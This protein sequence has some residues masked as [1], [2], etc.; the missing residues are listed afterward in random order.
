MNPHSHYMYMTP[1]LSFHSPPPPGPTVLIL[2]P[3][4]TAEWHSCYF[5]Q[6]R[7]PCRSPSKCNV[8]WFCYLLNTNGILAENSKA[9]QVFSLISRKALA[10]Q[11]SAE[12]TSYRCLLR[13]TMMQRGRPDA[14]TAVPWRRR[15]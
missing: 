10:F 1:I 3:Y 15:S 11:T 14:A 5:P 7:A 4:R 2:P 12:T 13:S 8:Y 9:M 6:I